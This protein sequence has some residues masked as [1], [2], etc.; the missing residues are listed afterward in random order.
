MGLWPWSQRPARNSGP[1]AQPIFRCAPANRTLTACI[2]SGTPVLLEDVDEEL[3]PLLDPLL[4]KDVVTEQGMQTI[5]IAESTVEYHDDFR[6][7]ITSRLPR[8]HLRPETSV[9]L[10]VLNFALTP[11]GLM[12]QLLQKVVQYEEK[13][14]EDRKVK[15][16]TQGAINRTRL[17][18]TEVLLLLPPPPSS[19]PLLSGQNTLPP[20]GGCDEWVCL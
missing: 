3:D 12:D 14:V 8:P 5:T 7:Y 1:K 13:E 2:K 11:T 20:R 16:I 6:L 19:R 17:R 9:K 10:T 18:K 15:F 4:R